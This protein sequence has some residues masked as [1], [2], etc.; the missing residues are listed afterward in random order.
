MTK[1]LKCG[2]RVVTISDN[3]Q[4]KSYEPKFYDLIKCESAEELNDA[5]VKFAQAGNA[6]M[7]RA[8]DITDKQYFAQYFEK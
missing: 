2:N 7:F 6:I 5:C 8:H 1:Y 4:Q 3:D